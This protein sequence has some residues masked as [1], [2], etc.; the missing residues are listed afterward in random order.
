MNSSRG[1]FS[2]YL[3][4]LLVPMLKLNHQTLVQ[5]SSLAILNYAES[6]TL[7]HETKS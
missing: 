3:P 7:R 1:H 4:D 5:I 2:I 6:T